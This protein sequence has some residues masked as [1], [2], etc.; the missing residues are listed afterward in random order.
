[1]AADFEGRWITASGFAEVS[2][3]RSRFEGVLRLS[4]D[5]GIYHRVAATIDEEGRVDAAVTSPE[6]ATAPFEL[7][8]ELFERSGADGTTYRTVLLTDGT[9]V[10]G[11]THGP[12]SN[13]DNL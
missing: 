2:L 6:T 8:G 1:L 13:E 10:L 4:A 12:R 5:A 7:R 11:L 9:T 3:D